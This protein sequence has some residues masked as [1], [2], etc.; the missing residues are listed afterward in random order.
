MIAGMIGEKMDLIIHAK[1]TTEIVVE[2]KLAMKGENGLDVNKL[3]RKRAVASTGLH[4]TGAK[5]E[6]KEAKVK[7]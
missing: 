2:P 3:F 7:R 6:P 5:E 4:S 1:E